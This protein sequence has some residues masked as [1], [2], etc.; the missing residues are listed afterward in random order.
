MQ[1]VKYARETPDSDIFSVALSVKSVRIR[2]C[3][4]RYFPANTNVFYAVYLECISGK[5]A[6]CFGTLPRKIPKLLWV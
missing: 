2:N 5:F 6:K 3:F 4:C 1:Y